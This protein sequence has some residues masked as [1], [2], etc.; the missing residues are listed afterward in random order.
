MTSFEINDKIFAKAV[1]KFNFVDEKPEQKETYTRL[2]YENHER[3][4]YFNRTD[5]DWKDDPLR[6]LQLR[7]QGPPDPKPKYNQLS[8]G[9]KVIPIEEI[10]EEP[11][12][13][14]RPEK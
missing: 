7:E 6:D 8:R 12:R 10:L 9:H 1:K 2:G 4:D 3:H 14:K 5:D 11:A 13:S